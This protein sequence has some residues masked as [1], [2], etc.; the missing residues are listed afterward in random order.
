ML[1]LLAACA[2]VH[3]LAAVEVVELS[4]VVP[5]ATWQGM[6]GGTALRLDL[7]ER[8]V[9]W[10]MARWGVLQFPAA[11]DLSAWDG[12]EVTI[13]TGQPRADVALDLGVME[14]DGSWYTVHEAIPLTLAKRTVRIAFSD[15]R[16]AEWVFDASGTCSGSD[17][18]FDEDFVCDLRSI[19]RLAIGAV[20]GR[21]VGVVTAQVD[22]VWLARWTDAGQPETVAVTI[23]GR[24]LV[25]NGTARIPDGIFGFHIVDRE[26]T[27]RVAEL[28]VGS[29][30]TCHAL[31]WGDGYAVPPAPEHGVGFV[32]TGLYDR[33]QQLP[34]VA[35]PVGW[36]N[37]AE[38]CARA[39]LASVEK[40]GFAAQAIVEFWNEPYLDLGAY[41][42][43]H[44]TLPLDNP[45]GIRA[46]D[47]VRLGGR[48]LPSLVW[49]EGVEIAGTPAQR[50]WPGQPQPPP[51]RKS[52]PTPDLASGRP[53]LLAVDPSRT[54]YWAGRQI[55]DFYCEALLAI[56]GPVKAAEPR[57][58]F[59]AGHGFRWNEDRWHGWRILDQETI[60]R[61]IAVIDGYAEHHYQGHVDG[62][63][64]SYDV[65]QAYTDR[66]HGRRLM[67]YNTEANDL[68]DTPA[69][70]GLI[71]AA[72]LSGRH[73][74][75]R[76]L[77]YNLRD[78]LG[79][80]RDVP[81]KLAARAIHAL[82]KSDAAATTPWG[83]IGINE[84]E[85]RCLMAL[86]HL[87]GRLLEVDCPDPGLLVAAALEDD[88][89]ALT[90]VAYRSAGRAVP[91][92]LSLSA[93]AGTTL[94][95]GMREDLSVTADGSIR[96]SSSVIELHGTTWIADIVLPQDS[97]VSLRIPLAGNLA[98][99]V[100]VTQEQFYA[101]GILQELRPGMSCELP[102]TL[103]TG[104]STSAKAWIQFV[105]EGLGPGEGEVVIAGRNLA[106]PHALTPPNASYIRRIAID[107]AWLDG[108]QAVQFRAQPASAGNGFL[109]CAASVVLER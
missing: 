62:S 73:V 42:D 3:I 102:V 69:R 2:L 17:G 60:D 41:L 63:H 22:S 104:A 74:A 56:A 53:V 86:R 26:A 90:V 43:S 10:S 40:G 103:P 96:H 87:R 13:T 49:V 45:D 81:D 91:L 93:P 100:P 1:R 15:L 109:L 67:A 12:V 107:P 39:I 58:R 30:R 64:A 11:A 4:T 75:A 21:G 99:L 97:C 31:R 38:S 57:I 54:S 34:Q 27:P 16:H 19:G 61:T 37:G 84:G 66:R 7:G 48:E 5:D 29:L 98:P 46:G 9:D 44:F 95:P 71:P 79:V 80:I 51:W 55:V 68:W 32:V 6:A 52:Q 83:R 59:V 105:A 78:I 47:R 35:D 18:N 72:A 33:K 106:L 25:V 108:V 50:W 89:T 70:G 23:S 82:W 88:G 77:G 24:P 65:L 8:H 94:L 28:R 101:T 76:R 14:A 92:R 85:Y 20:N 36:R